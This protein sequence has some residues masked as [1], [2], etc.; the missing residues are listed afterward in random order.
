MNGDQAQID[1]TV[2]VLREGKFISMAATEKRSGSDLLAIETSARL[3]DP[4]EMARFLAPIPNGDKL[5]Q[6]LR[7]GE[8]VSSRAYEDETGTARFVAGDGRIVTC[9]AV[10]DITIDQAEMIAAA[11]TDLSTLGAVEFER[12]VAIALGPTL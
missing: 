10:V 11:V 8:A 12:R 7:T 1:K 2:K 5:A 4:G 9:F 3:D 6:L